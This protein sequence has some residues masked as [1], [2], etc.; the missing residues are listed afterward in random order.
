ELTWITCSSLHSMLIRDSLTR[1]GFTRSLGIG[2]SRDFSNSSTSGGNSVEQIFICW[3]KSSETTFTTN[4]LVASTF[5]SVSF[6]EPSLSRIMG[7]KQITGG[8]ALIPVKKL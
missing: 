8:L 1:G 7:Q 3:A 4:S 5:R 6:F 2:V